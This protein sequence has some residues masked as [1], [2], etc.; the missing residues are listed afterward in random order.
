MRDKSKKQK[1][2]LEVE[3]KAEQ[4]RRLLVFQTELKETREKMRLLETRKT[5][6][7]SST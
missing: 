2:E 3:K 5:G 7:P 6:I 1:E 4:E